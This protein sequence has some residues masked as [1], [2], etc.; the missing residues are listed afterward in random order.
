MLNV[1]KNPNFSNLNSSVV[2][3]SAPVNFGNIRRKSDFRLRGTDGCF[4]LR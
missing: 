2:N 1:L 4:C 3:F